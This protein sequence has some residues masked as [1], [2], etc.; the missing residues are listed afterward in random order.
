M[1]KLYRRENYLSKIRGFYD[2]TMI[3]VITGIRRCGKSYL[4]KTVIE[5]LKEN[6]IQDKDIIFIELD[7]KGYKNITT[8]VELENTI[9]KLI[10]DNDFKYLFIDEVQN[11]EGFEKVI[12]AY[13][14]EENFSIFLTGSNSYLLSGEL[15]SKLTGRYIEIEMLPLNFYEYVDMKKFLGMEVNSNIY[16]EFEEFIRNG[17]FPGSLYYDK[18]E[19]KLTYTQSVISQIFEK[20][21]KPHKKIKDKALFEVIEKFVINNFGCI[22]SISSIYDYLTKTLKLS[23]DRRTISTYI[24]ILENAKIIYSCDLFDIK[25][26]RILKGEKKY[27]LADLSIFFAFNTDNRIN[28]GPV[29]EN[30]LFSYLKCR[31][32]SLSTG[33]IGTLECDFIARK[34][35]DQYYYIQVA[36]NIDD[37]KTEKREYKPFYAIKEMYPRYLFVS[38]LVL[39]KNVNGINNVN[40]VDFIYDRE[41]L[42]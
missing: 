25:S 40:I 10:T 42:K 31:N 7:K 12:N 33:R 21:I 28:Y 29:L 26:K 41:D 30:V 38:D 16:R 24:E 13:R 1:K 35:I 17:G 39:Q 23:V 34:G 4:L 32:Y 9:D 20:D 27:Y 19:D 5:E 11:V 3:K 8:G 37:E 15:A 2:D 6:G 22:I 36:K 18:Y 14:E